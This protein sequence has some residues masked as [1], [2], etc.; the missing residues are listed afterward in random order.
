[1]NR[2]EKPGSAS[3]IARDAERKSPMSSRGDSSPTAMRIVVGVMPA[4]LRA[5]GLSSECE[6]SAG[7]STRVLL[8]PSDTM[9]PN[10]GA[11]ES[12]KRSRVTREIFAASKLMVK[13][14]AGRPR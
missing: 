1:M 5:A 6:V 10:I 4:S 7:Q 3:S 8:W 12:K 11:S 9:W 2:F 13:S 14:G